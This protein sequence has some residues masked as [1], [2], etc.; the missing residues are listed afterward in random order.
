MNCTKRRTDS[1]NHAP[2]ASSLERLANVFHSSQP[3]PTCVNEVDTSNSLGATRDQYNSSFHE[4]LSYQVESAVNTN[5]YV[6]T[7]AFQI[8]HLES[9]IS[10]QPNIETL[11]SATRF[12][13]QTPIIANTVQ[14]NDLFMEGANGLFGLDPDDVTWNGNDFDYSLIDS[15][16]PDAGTTLL[17]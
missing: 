4:E 5:R 15:P 9:T 8:P 12:D 16:Y 1:I 7:L 14:G 11:R 6:S 13:Y 2:S 10:V 17:V 3:E